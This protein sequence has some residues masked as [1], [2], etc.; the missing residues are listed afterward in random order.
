[1]EGSNN[2]NA[3]VGLIVTP[4]MFCLEGGYA[5]VH[6]EDCPDDEE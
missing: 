1:M 6:P 3:D 2:Y 4:S 5:R